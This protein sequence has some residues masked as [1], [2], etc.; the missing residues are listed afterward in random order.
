[1]HVQKRHII[2]YTDS[3]RFNY[4]QDNFTDILCYLGMD[5]Y[6]SEDRIEIEK[7]EVFGGLVKLETLNNREEDGSVDRESL[8][9]CLDEIDMTL[10]EL[11][12][13]FKWLL[14]NSDPDNEYI[15]LDWF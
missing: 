12:D 1:M 11:I 10:Q 15:F 6:S 4:N 13:L 9:E 8:E 5:Y 14:K 7:K 2:E 3:G